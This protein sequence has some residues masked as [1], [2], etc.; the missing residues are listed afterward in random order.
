MRW[1]ALSITGKLK[2]IAK[3]HRR[4]LNFA[5]FVT[6]RK[7][8]KTE[9]IT[10]PAG[11]ALTLEWINTLPGDFDAVVGILRNGLWVASLIAVKKGLPLATPDVFLK[12]E[13]WFSRDK[14]VKP[15]ADMKKIL[16][17]EDS[18]GSGRSLDTYL[19]MF[20]PHLKVEVASL[21]VDSHAVAKVNYYGKIIEKGK[22]INQPN[23]FE[24]N[25]LTS[26]FVPQLKVVTDMDGVLCEDCPLEVDDD[27]EKYLNWLKNTPALI[28]PNAPFE[29][30]LTARLEKYRKPTEEWL[31]QH[32]IQYKQLIMLDLPTK[33]ERT[34]YKV[35]EHKCRYLQKINPRWFW[36]SNQ[37]EA[38]RIVQIAKVPV[39]CIAT[40]EAYYP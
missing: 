23:I 40:M 37:A 17:V 4:I 2:E 27:G 39:L 18:V 31:K 11:L 38:I 19:P 34:I 7:E 3:R 12:D 6:G 14:P 26:V 16:L 36:E 13:L 15:I 20:P 5:R 10:L 8:E 28:V 1:C 33:Q 30:I 32:R 21:Y 25:L 22:N 35:I 24:W 9:I 29:A